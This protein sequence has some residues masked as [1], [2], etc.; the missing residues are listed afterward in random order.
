MKADKASVMRLLK[1]AA[2]QIEGVMKMVEEDRYCLDIS[3]QIMAAEKVLQR[4]NRKVVTAHMN[5]CV[6][7]AR[8]DE[9][10]EEKIEEMIKLLEKIM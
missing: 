6:M 4:A 9:E 2:G 8:T 10:R 3:N 5:G 1:T 7:E